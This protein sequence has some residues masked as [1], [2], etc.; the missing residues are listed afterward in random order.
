[1]GEDSSTGS[2]GGSRRSRKK[3][4]YP[5]KQQQ[6]PKSQRFTG[7]CD[8]PKG[9]VFDVDSYS[10]S[11]NFTKTLE[12]LVNYIGRSTGYKYGAMVAQGVEKMLV[13]SFD[14]P[15]IPADYGTPNADKQS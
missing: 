3:G 8:D 6:Q 14:D 15:E 1:M 12:Q 9:H 4:G 13:P 5:K 10:P 11:D 7:A 2:G